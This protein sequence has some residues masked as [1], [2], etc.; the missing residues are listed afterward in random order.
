LGCALGAGAVVRIAHVGAEV[1]GVWSVEQEG[2]SLIVTGS[3]QSGRGK[4]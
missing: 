3:R 1:S 4:R 2:N